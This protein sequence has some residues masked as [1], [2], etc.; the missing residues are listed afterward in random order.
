MTEIDCFH[1]EFT[2]MPFL[3]SLPKKTK[4]AVKKSTRK[5]TNA[6]AV[7]NAIKKENKE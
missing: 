3:Q 4:A 5:G 2:R 7:R 1:R 6:N